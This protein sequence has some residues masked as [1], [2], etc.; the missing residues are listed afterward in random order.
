MD[1]EV[2]SVA[3][4]VSRRAESAVRR[5][6]DE[7]DALRDQQVAV[8]ADS[9]GRYQPRAIVT[10]GAREVLV[11]AAN[12]E[13]VK[14]RMSTKQ[15]IV[16]ACWNVNVDTIR[17]NGRRARL[18]HRHFPR[19]PF[20]DQLIDSADAKRVARILLAETSFD[21]RMSVQLARERRDFARKHADVR[22]K[23]APTVPWRRP[24]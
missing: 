3:V 21:V 23:G 7:E 10:D 4:G 5:R 14:D 18:D 8:R 22:T 16:H 15:L 17:D 9:F 24:P 20:V 6:A 2:V 12:A 1:G 19:R 13:Q 11:H